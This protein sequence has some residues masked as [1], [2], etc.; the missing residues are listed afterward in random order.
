M[1]LAE[2]VKRVQQV[3]AIKGDDERAHSMEDRLY[4]DFVYHVSEYGNIKLRE[5]AKEILKTKD[6]RFDRWCA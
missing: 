4:F 2:A 1:N 6:I 3:E 5:I